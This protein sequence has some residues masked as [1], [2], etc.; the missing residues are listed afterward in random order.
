MIASAGILELAV[1]SAVLA[2]SLACGF[3]FSGLETGVY[4]L[5]KVRLELRA[6][7]GH[8]GARR[9][10]EMLGSGDRLLVVLLIGSNLVEYVTTW[11]IVRLFLQAG[12]GEHAAS[13][14]TE[15]IATTAIFIL[16]ESLPK[17]V[18]RLHAERLVYRW[19]WFLRAANR[20]FTVTG[21]LPLVSGVSWAM[22]RLVRGGKPGPTL[23]EERM[24][25]IFAEG[26]AG[27]AMTHTQT[28][29]AD[30]VMRLRS[31]SLAAAMV[32]LHKVATV[33]PDATRQELLRVVAS[34]N[35]SRLP[36]RAGSGAIL[37]VLDVYDVLADED[38]QRPTERMTDPLILIETYSIS[39]ALY[40]MQ[41]SHR[42]MAVVASA[43]GRH[44]GIVTIKDLV[45]EIVGELEAW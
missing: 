45:E 5:N 42:R 20:L 16:G 30:R 10:A 44:V 21:L 15:L 25:E 38:V 12:T 26:Q 7:S 34:T 6:S 13:F 4:T 14:Y 33:A 43:A 28:V 18:F 36:V 31:V 39:D 40:H 29:M 9:L 37:G 19:S 41:R 35:F 11:A 3:L 32:P 17:N 2:A 27:G 1:L 23:S 22:L 24:A 8:V